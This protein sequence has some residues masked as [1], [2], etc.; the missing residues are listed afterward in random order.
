MPQHI[1]PE[2]LIQSIVYRESLVGRK[3]GELS[4]IR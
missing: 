2:V 1:L 3:F 4:T